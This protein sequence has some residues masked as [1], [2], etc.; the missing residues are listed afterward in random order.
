MGH[1]EP[2]ALDLTQEYFA[3]LVEKPVLAAADPGHGRFR[4]FLRDDCGYFL[5]GRCDREHAPKRG[6]DRPTLSIDARDAEGRYAL[7]PAGVVTP[8]WLFDRAWALML[9]A[10]ALDRLAADYAARGRGP[11]FERLQPALTVGSLSMPYAEIAQALGMSEAAV[12]QAASRL[13]KGFREVLRAELAATLDDS[14]D[15]AI[16]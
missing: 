13:R 12:Q 16:E 1:G 8:D 14:S 2:D 3:R 10:R 6:G 5:A 7:E 11:L 4:A 9:L 15:G